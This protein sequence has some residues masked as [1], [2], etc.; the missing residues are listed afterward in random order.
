MEAALRHARIRHGDRVGG[1][2]ELSRVGHGR[3]DG[4]INRVRVICP[5]IASAQA[6]PI[7]QAGFHRK[8]GSLAA[9]TSS[10]RLIG[11]EWGA[12]WRDAG[13]S[14]AIARRTLANASSVSR[15]SVSVGSIIM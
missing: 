1:L 2:E 12:S 11:V 15:L 9:M 10:G 4:R 6:M 14:D 8:T 13:S 3:H 7:V 5:G